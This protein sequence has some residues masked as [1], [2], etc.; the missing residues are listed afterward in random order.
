MN[1]LRLRERKKK[2]EPGAGR[3]LAL[4]ASVRTVGGDFA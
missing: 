3:E 2:R 1:I 4:F